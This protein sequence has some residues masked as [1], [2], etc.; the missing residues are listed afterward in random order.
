M[1]KEDFNHLIGKTRHEVKQELGDGF[2]FFTD[3]TWTYPIG[4]TWI[5]KKIILS[6]GFKDGKVNTIDLY[7]TFSRS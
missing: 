5:G 4:R 6:I 3:D 7:K 1:K 2:N